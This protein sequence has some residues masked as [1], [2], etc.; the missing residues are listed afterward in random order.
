MEMKGMIQ[1]PTKIVFSLPEGRE[2]VNPSPDS[3]RELVLSRGDDFWAAGSGQA[4]L[5]FKGVEGGSRLLLTAL[6]KVGFFLIYEPSKGE[7]LCPINPSD[8]AQEQDSVT[9]YVGGEPMEVPRQNFLDKETAW[10]VIGDFLH[11]GQPSPRI[12]WEAWL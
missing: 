4:A 11:D 2:Q 10:R 9:V 8:S 12:K 6:D 3:L 7:S 5:E 1:V